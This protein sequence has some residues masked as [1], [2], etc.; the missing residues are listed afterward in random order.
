MKPNCFVNTFDI[1]GKQF[2]IM[3]NG[4]SKYKTLIGSIFGFI[5]IFSIIGI[6]IYLISDM[7][8]NEVKT[9]IYNEN[10][11]A[12][13]VNNFTN[14]PFMFSVYDV[15]GTHIPSKGLYTLDVV[16]T[17][18]IIEN[19]SSYVKITPLEFEICDKNKHFGNFIEEFSIFGDNLQKYYC[20]PP[21][22][23]NLT[24][25]GKF[26]DVVTRWSQIIIYIS[27]CNSTKEACKTEEYMSKKLSNIYLS[28]VYLSNQIDNKN[29][30]TPHMMKVESTALLF[31]YSTIKRYFYQITQVEYDTDEGFFFESHRID[32]FHTF[33]SY[34]MDVD[35]NTPGIIN[36]KA[37]MG[38]VAIRNSNFVANYF[39]S[40]NKIATIFATL[41]GIIKFIISVNNLLVFVL[42]E[43]LIFENLSKSIFNFE[44]QGEDSP[45]LTFQKKFLI[46]RSLM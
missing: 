4:Q 16:M 27:K 22:K 10:Q 2:G 13:P 15:G 43:N 41:G 34:T 32:K 39:R 31:S 9:I 24:V 14:I 20:L 8:K 35:L 19:N 18:L 30:T 44:H 29:Y 46:L 1:Y 17:E 33:D 26:G 36:P 6:C 3:V 42:T 38:S 37:H 40:Y 25:F 28:M 45:K 23:N 7:A 12:I 11:S 21:G 5:S